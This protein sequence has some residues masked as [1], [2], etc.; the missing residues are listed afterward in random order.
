MKNKIIDF[1][2]LETIMLDMDGTVLDLHFDNEFWLNHLPQKYA[3]K[4][5]ISFLESKTIP[6]KKMKAKEG[7][8]QG[9]LIL[10]H[11][12]LCAQCRNEVYFFLDLI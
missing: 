6:Q 7:T 4:E 11:S 5:G 9:R 8:G 3:L 2:S 12:L 10:E 1:D